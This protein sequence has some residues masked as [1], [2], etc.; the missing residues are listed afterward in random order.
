M[1]AIQVVLTGNNRNLFSLNASSNVTAGRG[2]RGHSEDARSVFHYCIGKVHNEVLRPESITYLALV[3]ERERDGRCWSIGLGLSAREEEGREE[4]LGAFIAPDQ[5]LRADDFLQDLGDGRRG[6]LAKLAKGMSI[7]DR[8][9]MVY[10]NDEYRRSKEYLTAL[11]SRMQDGENVDAKDIDTVARRTVEPLTEYAELLRGTRD[12]LWI[13]RAE[14]QRQLNELQAQLRN[15]IAGKAMTNQQ[16]HLLIDRLGQ[17]GIEATPVAELVEV[18]DETWRDAAETLLGPAREALVV[19]P[20]N[21]RSAI[22]ILK[23][24]RREFAGCQVV[25]TTKTDRISQVPAADSLAAIIETANRHARAF[26]NTRLNGVVRVTTEQELLRVD[27]GVTPE[28][29][30]A[31]GGSIEARRPANQH[32]LGRNAGARNRPLLE[33][34]IT[35][36]ETELERSKRT[37]ASH[38]GLLDDMEDFL[39]AVSST[40]GFHELEDAVRA[41]NERRLGIEDNIR[42]LEGE[43][44]VEIRQRLADLESDLGGYDDDIGQ[45]EKKLKVLMYEHGPLMEKIRE[46]TEEL[47]LAE[48][49]FAERD[50]SFTELKRESAMRDYRALL[51]EHRSTAAVREAANQEAGSAARRASQLSGSAPHLARSFAYEFKI[52]D[53]DPSLDHPQQLAWLEGQLAIIEGNELVRYKEKAETAR[54]AVEESL[55]TDLL[56]KLYTKIVGAREHINTLNGMLRHRVFHRER[57]NFEVRPDP[58]YSD[59][60]QVAKLVYENQ[61]DAMDL[62]SGG[63]ELEGEVARGVDR[64]HRMLEGGDDVSEIS[65]YRNYLRFELVTRRAEDDTIAS[66]YSKRQ[67][68]GSG[69]EKEVPFYIA[70]SSA[71]A[72]TCHHREKVREDMGLGWSSSMRPSTRS[73]VAT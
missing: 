22:E 8:L 2:R 49:A 10:G 20:A 53:F 17:A 67:Q 5:S 47:K 11:A 64:I 52:P 12:N 23:E 40:I 66:E 24:G 3:F 48:D 9:V 60:V 25:N 33:E 69:G 38:S 36:V 68:S 70:I 57:Y 13:E 34:R 65:D 15:V 16:T 54:K 21:A 28:C 30:S 6:Q 73:T 18:I 41:A 7:L 43:R 27:R 44:P 35:G 71:M 55:R 39:E 58:A 42:T 63:A 29:L 37:A 72:A 26:I 56:I 45:D 62:F 32:L 31:S 50:A 51:E 61:A 19:D 59:I 1:D 4:T 46:A 14:L